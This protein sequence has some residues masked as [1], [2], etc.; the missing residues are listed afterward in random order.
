ALRAAAVGAAAAAAAVPTAAAAVAAGALAAAALQVPVVRRLHVRDVQ[1]AVAADA[2]VHERRLDARLDV[3][4]AALVDVAHVALVAG[5]LHVQLFQDAVFDDG[6]AALLRLEDVNQHL[7][8]HVYPL[9]LQDG[10]GRTRVGRRPPPF[11]R[12]LT[13]VPCAAARP[14]PS[15]SGRP[16]PGA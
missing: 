4:D 8:L 2:E 10:A 3:D 6:D 15:P 13:P 5:P 1:E 9:W 11:I 14:P 7:F 12:R 16:G